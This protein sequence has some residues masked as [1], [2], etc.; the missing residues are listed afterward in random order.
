M[1]KVSEMAKAEADAAEQENP[2]E[3]AEPSVPSPGE[4]DDDDDEAGENPDA[5]TPGDGEPGTQEAMRKALE[6]EATRHYNALAKL[7]PRFDDTFSP[8]PLCESFG[9]VPGSPFPIDPTREICDQC[10][11][12]GGTTTGSHVPGHNVE[13]CTKCQGNGWIVKTAPAV[14]VTP[15]YTPPPA[16]ANGAPATTDPRVAELQAEG[17][18]VVPLNPEVA[19]RV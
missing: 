3:P 18:M 10:A 19:G 14:P 12:L 6:G 9:Y 1:S 11:G 13:Q 2:D 8:C 7:M 4:P 5:E 15:A 17:Y 16:P